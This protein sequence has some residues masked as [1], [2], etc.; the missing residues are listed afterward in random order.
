[1]S[2]SFSAREDIRE[3]YKR[4]LNDSVEIED[5]SKALL[6][7]KGLFIRPPYIDF[8]KN[9]TYVDEKS[10]LRGWFGER[11]TLSAQEI[12]HI[13]TNF[14]NHTY[15]RALFIGF[16]QVAESK[17]IREF[18]IRGADIKRKII[19]VQQKLLE[20]SSLPAP[21]TWDTEVTNSTISPFSDKLML[22]LVSVLVSTELSAT[23]ASLAL[24]FRR[25][26]IAKYIKQ[27]S[28]MGTYAEDAANILIKNGWFER[29]P[30]ATDREYLSK[31]QNNA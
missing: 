17:E 21:M 11:R 23:G 31:E 5:K 1:M 8:P 6:L 20:E 25:D 9:V 12:A 15:S 30:Q 18:F 27:V 14:T 2:L 22:Y 7:S 4:Y 29:P 28:N 16:S 3:V 13:Y 24:T 10:F 26:L 19:N